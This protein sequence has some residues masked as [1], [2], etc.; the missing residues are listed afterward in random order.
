[1]LTLT[2]PIFTEWLAKAQEVSIYRLSPLSNF[3][4]FIRIAQCEWGSKRLVG[5]GEY[6]RIDRNTGEIWVKG[7]TK[8][9]RG[10]VFDK[11]SW[12]FGPKCV[13]RFVKKEI[14]F[15]EIKPIISIPATSGMYPDLNI[16][17]SSPKPSTPYDDFME[18]V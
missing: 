6:A 4:H 1:M 14:K 3:D 17:R 16:L 9:S 10:N 18:D 8:Y 11:G 15:E 7:Q 12:R 13:P 5:H 2:D